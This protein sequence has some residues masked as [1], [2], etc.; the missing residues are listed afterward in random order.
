MGQTACPRPAGDLPSVDAQVFRKTLYI[1]DQVPGRVLVQ[2]GM[3][4]AFTAPALIKQNDTIDL[5]VEVTSVYRMN[6]A[7]GTA[8]QEND[9]LADRKSVV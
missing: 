9:G 5:R 1:G 6:S 2:A 7:A 8:V 4:R 3:R